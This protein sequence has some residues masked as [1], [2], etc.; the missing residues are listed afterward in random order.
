MGSE[1]FGSNPRDYNVNNLRQKINKLVG[2]R[3]S[4]PEMDFIGEVMK[5][6]SIKDDDAFMALV[7]LYQQQKSEIDH[8]LK[9]L[10]ALH[11]QMQL[12]SSKKSRFRL[13]AVLFL[14]ASALIYTDPRARFQKMNEVIKPAI[15]YK[16]ER[17]PESLTLT[18]SPDEEGYYFIW[19]DFPQAELKKIKSDPMRR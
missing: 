1:I 9:N 4:R 15:M 5:E 3:L 11:G 8:L 16:I 7:V 19:F 2:K 17:P 18:K 13:L 6:F 14:A 12:A 10:R